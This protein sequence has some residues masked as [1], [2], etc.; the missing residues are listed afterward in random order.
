[1]NKKNKLP[2]GVEIPKTLRETIYNYLKVGIVNGT[3]KSGQRV[4]EKEIASLFAVS[5]TPVREAVLR[6]GAEGYIDIDSHRKAIVKEVSFEEL[7]NILQVLAAIDQLTTDQVI[8]HIQS[9]SVDMIEKMTAN[10]KR[11]CKPA[12]VEK[13]L[14]ANVAIHNKIWESLPNKILE[15]TLLFVHG[16]LLRY[17]HARNITFQ[18]PGVLENSMKEHEKILEA[19]KERNKKE[20]RSIQKKH[21]RTPKNYISHMYKSDKYPQGGETHKFL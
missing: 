4:I 6:L 10:M 12:T 5:T 19:L 13:Y 14:E 7:K 1:M 15:N 21:W 17:N 16:Q 20:L 8:D 9:E 3:I 11:F 18:K 2:S